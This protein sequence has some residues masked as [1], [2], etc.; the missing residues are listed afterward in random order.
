M[1]QATLS[2]R[3]DRMDKE[4]FEAFC[5]DAGL[6]VSVAINMFI[7]SVIKNQKIPFEITGDPFYSSSNMAHLRRGIKELDT[8][9]GVEH[10]LIEADE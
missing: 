7:K 4:H 8:G 6:N 3:L 1:A 2:V 9:H 5:Q 10:E